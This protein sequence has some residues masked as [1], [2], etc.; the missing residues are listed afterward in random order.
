MEAIFEVFAEHI[1]ELK[2]ALTRVI[3]NVGTD[4]DCSCSSALDDMDLPHGWPER[5]SDRA[6]AQAAALSSR[7]MKTLHGSRT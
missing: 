5:P 3:A 6:A 4:R 2:A 7:V 1:D